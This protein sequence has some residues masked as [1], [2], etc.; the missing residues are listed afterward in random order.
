LQKLAKFVPARYDKPEE[1]SPVIATLDSY[2]FAIVRPEPLVAQTP[3][4]AAGQAG[5]TKQDAKP[6]ESTEAVPAAELTQDAKPAE[7]TEAVH[8]AA[9][10]PAAEPT[11]TREA[12]K[13]GE[14]VQDAQDSGDKGGPP[15]AKAE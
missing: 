2:V 4:G 9:P 13:V 10:A 7:A 12:A 15:D 8:V 1:E 14:S 11:E 6:A 5:E 3:V